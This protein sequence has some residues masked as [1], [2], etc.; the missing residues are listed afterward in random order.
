MG[1]LPVS[2]LGTAELLLKFDSL[3]DCVNSSTLTSVKEFKSAISI[4]NSHIKFLQES[5][6]FI[7]GIKVFNGD[8]NVTTRIKSLKVGWS[9][10]TPLFV[11][12]IKHKTPT[13]SPSCSPED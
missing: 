8:V 13:T 10:S 1:G 11:F 3:F 12:G 7:Q 5:I 6:T 4:N 9:P 2:S